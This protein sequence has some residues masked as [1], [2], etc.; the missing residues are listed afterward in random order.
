MPMIMMIISD[1]PTSG[2]PFN[3]NTDKD[4]SNFSVDNTHNNN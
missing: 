4:E 3:V 1:R 2:R